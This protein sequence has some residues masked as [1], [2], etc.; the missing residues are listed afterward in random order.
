MQDTITY[1]YHFIQE[2]FVCCGAGYLRREAD[3]FDQLP[4]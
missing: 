2:A 3:C 4:Q 1:H